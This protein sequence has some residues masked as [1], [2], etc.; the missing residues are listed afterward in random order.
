MSA[1]GRECACARAR[2]RSLHTEFDYFL[3]VRLFMCFLQSQRPRAWMHAPKSKKIPIRCGSP[4]SISG[5][6]IGS[7]EQT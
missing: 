4:E 6:S 7:T 5:W 3:F 2:V 1:G